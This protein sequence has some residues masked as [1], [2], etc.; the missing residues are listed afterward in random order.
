LSLALH[1]LQESGVSGDE[2]QMFLP[3][4]AHDRMGILVA[5]QD[6]RAIL[7]PWYYDLAP[8]SQRL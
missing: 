5:S 7:G 3:H 4:I 1:N 8:A 2:Q 6:T